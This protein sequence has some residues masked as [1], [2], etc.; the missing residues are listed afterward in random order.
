MSIPFFEMALY[1]DFCFSIFQFLIPSFSY[2]SASFFA[3]EWAK[4]LFSREKNRYETKQPSISRKI[5]NYNVNIQND[6]DIGEMEIN[7][8]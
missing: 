6:Q 4:C 1:N 2:V 5:I 3:L 8:Y 7:I